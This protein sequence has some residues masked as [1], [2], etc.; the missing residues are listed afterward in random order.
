MQLDL[1]QGDGYTL[2]PATGYSVREADIVVADGRWYA[3][4]DLVSWTNPHHPNTYDSGI[5]RFISGDGVHWR[6][7]RAVL[8]GRDGQWDEGGTATPG[9]VVCGGTTALFYSG[10]EHRDGTGY[11][12][13]GVAL[14]P[15]PEGEFQALPAP[16]IVGDGHKDDPCPVLW[17]KRIFLYYRHTRADGYAICLATATTAAGPWELHGPVIRAG[18]DVRAVE[19]TDACVVGG[20]ILL[21]VMEHSHTRGLRTALYGSRD[22]TTF[23]RL[24]PRYL[25]DVLRIPIGTSMG[26]HATFHVAEDGKVPALSLTRVMGAAGHY[27]RVV[28]PLQALTLHP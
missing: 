11:R 15:C 13:I 21:A 28:L 4:A 24:L 27:T 16:I 19:T 12:H 14:A 5:D 25:E 17:R 26:S 6:H 8:R 18:G 23:S 22:G 7:D 3:F 1:R 9:A 20:C 2:F 10:R